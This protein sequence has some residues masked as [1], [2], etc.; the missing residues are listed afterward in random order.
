[1]TFCVTRACGPAAGGAGDGGQNHRPAADW[2]RDR[3][4]GAL[5]PP[6]MGNGRGNRGGRSIVPWVGVGLAN[7]RRCKGFGLV[8]HHPIHWMGLWDLLHGHLLAAASNG[9]AV[10]SLFSLCVTVWVTSKSPLNGKVLS[11]FYCPNP[12]LFGKH[13][14]IISHRRSTTR[15]RFEFDRFFWKQPERGVEEVQESRQA[16]SSGLTSKSGGSPCVRACGVN[17]PSP[18]VAGCRC[19]AAGPSSTASAPI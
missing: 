3:A 17:P 10:Q 13:S 14:K 2:W 5:L 19:C 8:P 12:S 4:G 11:L 7:Q 1:M 15:T 9:F 6:P 16:P 18:D